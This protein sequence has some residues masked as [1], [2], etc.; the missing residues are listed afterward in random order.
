M[1]SVK[2]KVSFDSFFLVSINLVAAMTNAYPTSEPIF[3]HIERRKGLS[4]EQ[5][6]ELKELANNVASENLGMPSIFIVAN[7]MQEWLQENNSPGQDGSMYSGN[8]RI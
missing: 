4:I 2:L 5:G 8:G 3:V 6:D 1:T 7:A